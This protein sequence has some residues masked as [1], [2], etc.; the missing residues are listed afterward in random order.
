MS[1]Y[2]HLRSLTTPHPVHE[3]ALSIRTFQNQYYTLMT[4]LVCLNV[5]IWAFICLQRLTQFGF[6]SLH[7][8]GDWLEWTLVMLLLF[9]SFIQ[10]PLLLADLLE[11]RLDNVKVALLKTWKSTNYQVTSCVIYIPH[12]L[13]SPMSAASHLSW[14]Q[15]QTL[16]RIILGLELLWVFLF[17]SKKN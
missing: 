6:Q 7:F 1:S 14:P 3:K 15:T 17:P 13:M 10:R 5:A 2:S 16:G 11:D 9:Q 8:R 4:H 12:S